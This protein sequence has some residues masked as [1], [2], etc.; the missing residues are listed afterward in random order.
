[1]G[2]IRYL[3]NIG[4]K[5][6]WLE[7]YAYYL[8][9]LL[10]EKEILTHIYDKS[11][12]SVSFFRDIEVNTEM[13]NAIIASKGVAL[14]PRLQFAIKAFACLFAHSTLEWFRTDMTFRAG[15]FAEYLHQCIPD[16]LLSAWE[17]PSLAQKL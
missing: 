1:M 9:F 8:D 6:S 3:Y 11:Y 12:D 15:E 14:D 16:S 5:Y 2:R 13:V 4:T 10:A 7:G 17:S